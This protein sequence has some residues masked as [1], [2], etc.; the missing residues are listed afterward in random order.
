MSPR[1]PLRARTLERVKQSV[2]KNTV[3]QLQRVIRDAMRRIR[4]TDYGGAHRVLYDA[5][6]KLTRLLRALEGRRQ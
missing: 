2:S 5:D 1:P 4:A 6:A 3:N